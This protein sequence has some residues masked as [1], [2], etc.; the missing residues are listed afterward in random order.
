[1]TRAVMSGFGCCFGVAMLMCTP[2]LFFGA[3]DGTDASAHTT[4]SDR[5]AVIG[6]TEV[7]QGRG[8]SC[9]AP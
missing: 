7:T 3:S 6:Q 1:M 8:R 2:L 9:N 5:I 4:S